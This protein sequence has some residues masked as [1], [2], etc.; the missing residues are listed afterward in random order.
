V[1]IVRIPSVLRGLTGGADEVTADG[2]TVGEVIEALELR[3]PGIRARLLDAAGVR[4]FINIFVGDE[5]VRF[6]E[7][8]QTKLQPGDH[9]S[10]IPAIAGG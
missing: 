4:R 3:H 8:L 9:V 5:D 2:A 7:G 10:I 6:L 1:A